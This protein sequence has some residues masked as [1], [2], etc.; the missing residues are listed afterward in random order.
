MKALFQKAQ[1]SMVVDHLRSD[2]V[3]RICVVALVLQRMP[4]RRTRHHSARASE[5]EIF[6]RIS[7]LEIQRCTSSKA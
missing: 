7:H 3:G 4:S 6:N 2:A 5:R 1:R